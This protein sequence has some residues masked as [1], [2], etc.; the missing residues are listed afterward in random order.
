MN[1]RMFIVFEGVDGSGKST[2]IGEVE[3]AIRDWNKYQDIVLTREPTYKAIEVIKKLNE[4]TDPKKDASR[5][6]NLFVNDRKVHYNNEILPDLLKN[7]V[8]ICDRYSM[9]TLAYQSTQG[10]QMQELIHA[11]IKVRIGVPDISFYM[12]LSTQ[13]A[14]ERISKRGK[15]REKFEQFKFIEELV[16]R[17]EFIYNQSLEENSISRLL[18]NVVRIDASREM[19]EVTK[20]I[21]VE[22]EPIYKEHTK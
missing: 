5:M 10:R 14:M 1:H 19:G 11:H 9:S 2:Q 12:A 18:G 13:Q 8:V 22:L 7:R 21:L 3:K 20:S 15:K 17:H 4:D 16:N 6:S